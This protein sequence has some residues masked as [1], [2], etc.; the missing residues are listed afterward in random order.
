MTTEL[1]RP[2]INAFRK[3]R[4]VTVRLTNPN[5]VETGRYT[6]G[7]LPCEVTLKLG[8]KRD[9]ETTLNVDG[10]V[11]SYSDVASNKV[12]ESASAM[13]VATQ[14]HEEYMTFAESLRVGDKLKFVFVVGG[15]NHEN[16]RKA[17]FETY[18]LTARICRPHKNGAKYFSYT[19]DT[20]IISRD[21]VCRMVKYTT[22]PLVL[23]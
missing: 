20:D 13:V 14:H 9:R 23:S 15:K 19:L 8:P 7:S 11:Y 2:D 16:L 3:A 17:G 5:L 21:N 18:E 12:V 10:D 1:T 22:K 6:Y 4:D